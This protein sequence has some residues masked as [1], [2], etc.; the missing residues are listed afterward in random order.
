MEWLKALALSPPDSLSF[1][2]QV[3]GEK[4]KENAESKKHSRGFFISERKDYKCFY[5]F[6]K[7]EGLLHCYSLFIRFH[8]S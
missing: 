3:D 1:V 8:F 4:K 5:W 7:N 2:I 6:N